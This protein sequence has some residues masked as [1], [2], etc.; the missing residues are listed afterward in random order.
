MGEK[1][2]AAREAAGLTQA[3]LAEKIGVLQHHISRYEAGREPKA[4]V[5]KK[6]AEALNCRMEDLV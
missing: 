4:L 3:Q 5:L 2:K 6:M 1:L